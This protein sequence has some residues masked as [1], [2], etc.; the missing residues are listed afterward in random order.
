MK[1]KKGGVTACC[2]NE[3]NKGRDRVEGGENEVCNNNGTGD[4][5]SMLLELIGRE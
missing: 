3:E 1:E 2:E 5:N 4:I